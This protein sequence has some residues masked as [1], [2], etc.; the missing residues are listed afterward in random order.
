MPARHADARNVGGIH[1]GLESLRCEEIMDDTSCSREV[2]LA[3][4]NHRLELISAAQH[5]FA[6]DRAVLQEQATRLRL[7]VPEDEVRAALKSAGFPG[8][9]GRQ[10]DHLGRAVRQ[11]G[12]G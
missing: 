8:R 6:L 11:R 3:W 4:I 9:A 10:L 2:L 5:R 1:A 12:N 7:G